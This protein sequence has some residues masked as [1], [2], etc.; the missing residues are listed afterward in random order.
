MYE[1]LP[2]LLVIIFFGKYAF[3]CSVKSLGIEI[4]ITYRCIHQRCMLITHMSI[5]LPMDIFIVIFIVG[6]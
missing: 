1:I 6:V 3:L 2:S 5:E 4:Y